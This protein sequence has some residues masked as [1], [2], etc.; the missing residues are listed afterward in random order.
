[1]YFTI[2]SLPREELN[3]GL[4]IRLDAGEEVIVY[5]EDSSFENDPEIHPVVE[6]IQILEKDKVKF[7]VTDSPD[8]SFGI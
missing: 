2:D 1:M 6:G 8:C 7:E 5:F 4:P 3:F